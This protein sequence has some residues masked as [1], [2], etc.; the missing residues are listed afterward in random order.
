M[1]IFSK[2]ELV[3]SGV[4]TLKESYPSVNDKNIFT[5]YMYAALFRSQLENLSEDIPSQ[6]EVC[7]ELIAE[8]DAKRSKTL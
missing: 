7:D 3:R 4:R 2:Q 6:K 5:D 1:R 8:I